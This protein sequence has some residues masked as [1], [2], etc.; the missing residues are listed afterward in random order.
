M[1]LVTIIFAFFGFIGICHADIIGPWQ[2]TLSYEGIACEP[3]SIQ[4]DKVNDKLTIVAVSEQNLVS[5]P[6]SKTSVFYYFGLDAEFRISGSDL[7]RYN[8]TAPMGTISSNTLLAQNRICSWDNSC[9]HWD[10]F[11]FS[12]AEDGKLNVWI[13]YDGAVLSG[14]MSR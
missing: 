13:N 14:V 6:N 3:V 4:I 10:N 12:I 11:K 7:W 1:K 2:G 8:A 5:C 9:R